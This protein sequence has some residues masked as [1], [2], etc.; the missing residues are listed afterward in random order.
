MSNSSLSADLVQQSLTRAIEFGNVVI[1]LVR[2]AIDHVREEVG[3]LPAGALRHPE[4][5]RQLAPAMV[6]L[7]I[8]QLIEGHNSRTASN[9]EPAISRK[10]IRNGAVCL[11]CNDTEFRL[12]KASRRHPTR[13]SG[14]YQERLINQSRY[15]EMLRG[16]QLPGLEDS[17]LLLSGL[18]YYDMIEFELRSIS[19]VIPD[20]FIDDRVHCVAEQKLEIDGYLEE[21]ATF[22]QTGQLYVTS[23]QSGLVLSEN[24]LP[25]SSDSYDPFV[26][27]DLIHEEFFNQNDTAKE[28]VFDQEEQEPEQ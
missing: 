8:H 25:D 19:V 18:I 26:E 16:E 1:P 22:Q 28:S 13:P 24:A 5:E 4:S 10:H 6:R 15:R 12:L 7:R 21:L 9:S 17:D 20:G 3:R 27:E 11:L 14:F 2:A 23:Q